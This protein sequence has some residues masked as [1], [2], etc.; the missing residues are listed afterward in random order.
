MLAILMILKLK[1]IFSF[2]LVLILLTPTIVKLEHHHNEF[3]CNAKGEK[4]FHTYNERC[5]VCN[6]EFSIFLSEKT[7]ISSI[8]IIK[9]NSYS[10]CYTSFPNS[11][12]SKYSF[13]LRAPPVFINVV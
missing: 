2:L 5:A 1:K 13:L 7:T 8:K 3:I 11:N 9:F 12:L 4:L 10:N 6:F